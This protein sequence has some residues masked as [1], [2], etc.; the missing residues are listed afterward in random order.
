MDRYPWVKEEPDDPFHSPQALAP[1]PG[2]AAGGGSG[3]VGG[4]GGGGC[5]GVGGGG[6][7]AYAAHGGGTRGLPAGP[8]PPPLA[9]FPGGGPLLPPVD[10]P[11]HGSGGPRLPP[12]DRRGRPARRPLPDVGGPP[13]LPPDDGGGHPPAQTDDEDEEWPPG[14]PLLPARVGGGGGGGHPDC[15]GRWRLPPYLVGPAPR[16]G[17]RPL[18]ADLA[19]PADRRG[20]P[21]HGSRR[22]PRKLG[23]AA[24]DRGGTPP[25]DLGGYRPKLDAGG[26]HF[27]QDHGGGGGGR[28]VV[29]VGVGVGVGAGKGAGDGAGGVFYHDHPYRG[30]RGEFGREGGAPSAL[31]RQSLA[32]LPHGHCQWPPGARPSTAAPAD[33]AAA[34]APRRAGG[35]G[36]GLNPY[37]ASSSAAYYGVSGERAAPFGGHAGG[38]QRT[39]CSRGLV[40]GHA[41]GGGGGSAGRTS[42]GHAGGA[43]GT[44]RAPVYVRGGA[45]ARTAPYPAAGGADHSAAALAGG[46]LLGR[47]VAYDGGGV[48]GRGGGYPGGVSAGRGRVFP[49]GHRAGQGTTYFYGEGGGGSLDLAA[50]GSTGRSGADARDGRDEPSIHFYGFGSSAP[51]RLHP[52]GRSA[53]RSSAYRGGG[54]ASWGAPAATPVPR[55]GDR[56]AGSS[57]GRGSLV[58]PAGRGRGRPHAPPQRPPRLES[59]VM[60]RDVPT[61]CYLVVAEANMDS[62]AQTFFPSAAITARAARGEGAS[63]ASADALRDER[64]GRAL[65]VAGAAA[66]AAAAAAVQAQAAAATA[67]MGGGR[68]TAAAAAQAAG[69]AANARSRALVTVAAAEAV[70]LGGAASLSV[71]VGEVPSGRL[72][73]RRKRRRK[74]A[75]AADEGDPKGVTPGQQPSPAG[76]LSLGGPVIHTS[77]A[78]AAVAAA[79]NVVPN[80][81]APLSP[82]ARDRMMKELQDLGVPPPLVDTILNSD[83]TA[84]LP[85]L[86]PAVDRP[87]VLKVRTKQRNRKSAERSRAKTKHKTTVA[88]DAAAE[89][90]RECQAVWEIAM[91]LESTNRR[92]QAAVEYARGVHATWTEVQAVLKLGVGSAGQGGLKPTYRLGE[93]LENIE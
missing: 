23:V 58:A 19:G 62:F 4:D 17:P 49:A 43:N 51:G 66:D 45:A 56:G 48:A 93:L 29:E 76:Q 50:G 69:V 60:V 39:V 85:Q 36:G 65:A 33:A 24:P 82:A 16:G 11:A 64:A 6:G 81:D 61:A 42:I 47:S 73:P 25:P 13:R 3:G 20:P 22:P 84:P 15:N 67:A 12:A 10:Q 30:A 44:V 14:P 40:P 7:V 72:P 83:L 32:T 75:A 8:P 52:G 5:D 79:A 89:V 92:L 86:P 90:W 34:G 41:A 88:K 18:P 35:P 2:R 55:V 28:P 77:A 1:P 46:A 38:D 53:G 80:Y 9:G 68:S 71:Q 78:A 54:G 57:S 26:P 87:A 91:R 74:G 37:G 21:D 63:T 27:P 31:P 70:V 59:V